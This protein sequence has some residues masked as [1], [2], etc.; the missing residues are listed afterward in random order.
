MEQDNLNDILGIENSKSKTDDAK[1]HIEKEELEKEDAKTNSV[2]ER[3]KIILGV[4]SQLAL[5]TNIKPII[6]RIIFIVGTILFLP[7]GIVVYLLI[8]SFNNKMKKVSFSIIGAILGIPLSYYFQSEMV[9]SKVGSIGGYLENF[10]DIVD[11]SDLLGNVIISIIVFALVGGVI[12]YFV[13]E[14]EAKKTK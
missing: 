5:K 2:G 11:N 13:D 14:N 7:L 6:I 4:C 8:F 10:G 3:K 9:R 12:G 1:A